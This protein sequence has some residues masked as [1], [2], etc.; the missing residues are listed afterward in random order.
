MSHAATLAAFAQAVRENARV[1]VG[2]VFSFETRFPLEGGEARE[3][4][5]DFIAERR[6]SVL[7]AISEA[8]LRDETCDDEFHHAALEAAR[9]IFNETTEGL[10]AAL[11]AQPVGHA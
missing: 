8:A 5:L 1:A 3:R 4:R 2:A 10:L 6:G 7:Q 11:D 9:A